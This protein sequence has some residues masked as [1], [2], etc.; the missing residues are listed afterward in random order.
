MLPDVAVHIIQ[1]GNNRTTCFFSEEDYARYLFH[2]ERLAPRF[3]CAVHAW[4]LM[5]NHVHLLVTPSAADSCA[6]LMK[7]LGQRYV[8]QVNRVRKRSGTLWEGR[9]R[10]SLVQSES[11]L[12]TCYRYIEL[13][14]VRAG[15]VVHPRS[16]P[17]SSY[18]VNAEGARSGLVTPH[19]EYLRLGESRQARSVAYRELV[20]EQIGDELTDEIRAATNGG[21]ALGDK[22]FQAQVALALGRPAIRGVPGR[23]PDNSG[24]GAGHQL[25]VFPELET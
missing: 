24:E 2:L 16:Y 7:N 20:A 13:N 14:P 9:F 12:L 15:M 19:F 22:A 6:L 8:Q 23:R 3:G 1:R 5:T 4:C 25:P 18:R 10:S 21:Y 17:W 11:Y